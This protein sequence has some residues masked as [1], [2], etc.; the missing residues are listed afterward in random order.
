MS[1][2]AITMRLQVDP[3]KLRTQINACFEAKR[4]VSLP[5]ENHLDNIIGLLDDMLEKAN[6]AENQ[7]DK[8]ET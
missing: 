6:N 4:S 7:R 5:V 2:V 3:D 8:D 1:T